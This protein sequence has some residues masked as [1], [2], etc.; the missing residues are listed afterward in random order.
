MS[1]AAAGPRAMAGRTV[2]VTGATSGIGL[3]AARKLAQMGARVVLG[4]RNPARASA[5]A[6]EI[7][8]RGG[9]AEV[10]PIDLASFESTREAAARFSPR[11]S[12]SMSSST[13]RARRSPAARSRRTATSG[14]GRPTSS[15]SSS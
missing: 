11:T 9:V 15:A 4:A 7:T 6:L 12:A 2:L 8:R 14:P 13:T 5:V 10:L 3:E 1:T